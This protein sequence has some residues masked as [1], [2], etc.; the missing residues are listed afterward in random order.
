MYRENRHIVGV[1]KKKLA[2]HCVYL[3]TTWKDVLAKNTG[4]HVTDFQAELMSMIST[5]WL[6]QIHR[7]QEVLLQSGDNT[8]PGRHSS[9]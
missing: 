3:D 9:W 4:V 1:S 5:L 6:H 7:Q 2:H 8:L